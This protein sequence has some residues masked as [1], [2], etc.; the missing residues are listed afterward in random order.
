MKILNKVGP[1]KYRVLFEVPGK[2]DF[3]DT[4]TKRMLRGKYPN[5]K[6]ALERDYELA[7]ELTTKK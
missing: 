5:V 6:S 1:N 2:K 4:I 3:E 7:H